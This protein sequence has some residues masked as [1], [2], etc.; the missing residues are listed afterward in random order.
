[1][2]TKPTIDFIAREV[3]FFDHLDLIWAALPS[4]QRGAFYV[5]DQVAEERKPLFTLPVD[6][7]ESAQRV[8]VV[9]SFRDL[10][11]AR[12]YGRRTVLCEHGAGQGY[13]GK[14]GEPIDSGSYIGG[15]DRAGVVAVM[16]PGEGQAEA[17]RRRHPTIPAFAV[18]CPKMDIHHVHSMGRRGDRVAISFH[19]DCRLV[20]ETRGAA[21]F[22]RRALSKVKATFPDVIGHG[23]PRAIEQ[24]RG[25]YGR[26]G[27]EVVTDFEEVIER[28]DIY[29]CDNS[30]TMFEWASLDRPVVVMNAKFY[31][32][33]VHH[34]MRFWD[35]ADMGVQVNHP[36]H[37]V[38]G[39]EK[40]I[41]DPPAI[42]ERRRQVADT[43]YLARDGKAAER[44]AQALATVLAQWG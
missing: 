35:H 19:W 7:M 17:H 28:A 31:R 24:L 41:A 2:G 34:G 30:S 22:Y 44:A 4:D 26:A 37:L 21:N 23:H 40:A 11:V 18:G 14:L 43:V 39:I 38:A 3:Q 6:S 1:M 8:A 36:D 9:A 13:I 12:W 29:A 32:R 42:A 20:P 5:S 15:G 25:L 33:D 27:I 10:K 16:V